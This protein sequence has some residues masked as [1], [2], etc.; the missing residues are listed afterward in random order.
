MQGYQAEQNQ[1]D[2]AA[3]L[4]GCLVVREEIPQSCRAKAGQKEHCADAKHKA[5]CQ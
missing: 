1:N 3:H 2:T 4:H 5:Q